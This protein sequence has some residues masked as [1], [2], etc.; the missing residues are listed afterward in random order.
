MI[1]AIYTVGL[2]LFSLGACSQNNSSVTSSN[3]EPDPSN[4]TVVTDLNTF[5][6]SVASAHEWTLMLKRNSGWFGG[7]GIFSVSLNGK[8]NIG[9]ANENTK[10]L[11]WFSDTMI[12][13]IVNGVLQS[14]YKMIHNSMAILEGDQPDKK[15][16]N[17][18]WD[19]DE[20]GNPKSLFIPSTPASADTEWYWLGDGFVNRKKDG[21]IYIF[22]YRIKKVNT[23]WGF[24]LAGSTLI[25]LPHNSKPPFKDQKQMDT[26]LFVAGDKEDSGY[27]FGAGV[28]VNTKAAGAPHP[29]GYVYIYGVKNGS[30]FLEKDLMVARVLP[31]DITDFDE[32]RFWDGKGWNL[33]VQHISKA[34]TITDQVSDELSLTPLPD[35]RYALVFQ[36]HGIGSSVDLR[37]AESP[38][39]PFGPVI[40]LWDCPEVNMGKDFYTYN[41]KAHP[42]LSSNGELLISYNVNAFNFFKNLNYHPYLYR[43][44]FIKIKFK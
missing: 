20:Q 36:D 6:F 18:Y 19:K 2:L 15:K 9:A 30:G 28:F 34:A 41:A 42:H 10:T 37:L 25:I 23:G 26:P 31:E 38:H 29:D 40:K 16:I 24:A 17:F 14:G 12:G 33:D 22:A 7:D 44:R 32:W 43:P 13:D 39:G 35:G 4:D 3:N 5:D 21:D 8:D 1:K 11:F 27:A